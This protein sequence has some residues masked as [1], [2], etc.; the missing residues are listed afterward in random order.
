MDIVA[1]DEITGPDEGVETVK[2]KDD[3]QP[4]APPPPPAP[5]RRA[6]ARRKDPLAPDGEIGMRLRELYS[7]FEKEP[8]PMQ[9]VDLLEKLSEAELKA[10]K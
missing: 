10:A 3:G 9:L 6:R 4:K 1:D 5:P 8:I 7:E 2:D